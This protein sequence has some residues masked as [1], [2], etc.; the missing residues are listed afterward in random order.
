MQKIA[1]A[2]TD[3]WKD[4]IN[5]QFVIH[6]LLIRPLQSCRLEPCELC[7]VS[8]NHL[9]SEYQ[10]KAL[11]HFSMSRC[12]RQSMKTEEGVVGGGDSVTV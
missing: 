12:T 1:I 6:G 2:W 4:K 8:Q 3:L 5:P 11:S 10:Q 7:K 9:L